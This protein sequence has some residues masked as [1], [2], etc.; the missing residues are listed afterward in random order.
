MENT[1]EVLVQ[2]M[3]NLGIYPS[4]SLTPE[5]TH[6]SRGP[7][8]CIDIS[9]TAL[10][11][12][13]S[14]CGRRTPLLSMLS[15]LEQEY[16][17]PRLSMRKQ[18]AMLW[19]FTRGY[20]NEQV[21]ELLNIS[22]DSAEE[23]FRRF[24]TLVGE[25]QEKANEELEVGGY[26]LQCEADEIAFRCKAERDVSGEPRILWLR[27]FGLVRRGSSRVFLALLPD[28]LVTGAGQGVLSWRRPLAMHP[29]RSQ[30]D[31]HG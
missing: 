14:K 22:R 25:H 31:W 7:M 5:C 9:S 1:P 12:R 30:K 6:C 27:Y 4:F 16:W 15:D 17:L 23:L 26:G 2:D 28:R 13:C 24:V 29:L 8:K 20:T 3:M 19:C 11:F 18:L 10:G 21:C